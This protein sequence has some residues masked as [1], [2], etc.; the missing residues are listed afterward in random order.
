MSGQ[1]TKIGFVASML[2]VVGSLYVYFVTGDKD[3]GIFVG[4]WAPTLLL[5]SKDIEEMMK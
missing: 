2:S 5:A 1:I 3:L 4:L